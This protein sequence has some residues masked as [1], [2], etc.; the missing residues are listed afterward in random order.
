VE[1][2]LN[3]VFVASV[4]FVFSA[5]V[6]LAFVVPV[7]QNPGFGDPEYQRIIFFHVPDAWIAVVAFAVSMVF[8]IRYLRSRNLYDD[9]RA[10][11]AA[12]LGLLFSLLATVTG[13][14]FAK[15]V[16]GSYWNWD[17]RETS[18]VLLMLV[19]F[20][21][22]ALRASVA[23]PERRAALCAAYATVA[24][25]TVPFFVFVA[26]R[27]YPSLHPGDTFAVTSGG[28]DMDGRMFAVFVLSLLSYT[29]LFVWVYRLRTR[30]ARVGLAVERG[31]LS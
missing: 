29:L 17:P 1:R 10:G 19:Y 25:V 15:S 31:V 18:I 7:P 16:W 20:A 3:R 8:S 22:F 13:S 27:V 4:L 6:V 11:A 9:G 30:I 26:P 28:F 24:F 21:Y 2:H 23:D 5:A 14:I 12:E